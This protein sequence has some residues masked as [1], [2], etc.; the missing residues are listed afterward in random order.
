MACIYSR[1]LRGYTERV[2]CLVHALSCSLAFNSS[3]VVAGCSLK[4]TYLIFEL[5]VMLPAA[6]L[7]KSSYSQDA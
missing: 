1:A 2:W 7:S 6:S 3:E 4:P 5:L